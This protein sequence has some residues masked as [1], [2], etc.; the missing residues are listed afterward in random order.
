MVRV[1]HHS[2]LVNARRKLKGINRVLYDRPP[3]SER[4]QLFRGV[5]SYSAA[6]PSG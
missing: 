6:N 3:V 4:Q 5:A 1:H 2:Y